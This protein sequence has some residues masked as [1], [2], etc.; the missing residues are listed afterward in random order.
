MRIASF[1]Q[2]VDVSTKQFTYQ[3]VVI[4]DDGHSH[5]ITTTEET[6]QQLVEKLSNGEATPR[7]PAPV[8]GPPPT[9]E[10][11]QTP[12]EE[13]EELASI[14]GGEPD[15]GE[16]APEPVMGVIA[17]NRVADVEEPRGLGS[18]PPAPRAAPPAPRVP[19]V[20]A[21]GF[22]LPIPSRTVPKDEMGYPIVAKNRGAPVLP[23]DTGD[24]G[25]QI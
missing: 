21:D 25:N 2:M 17:E 3:M 20:D 12:M 6:I 10:F 11:V 4:T 15:P 14:F 13:D 9:R 22:A 1:G 5:A 7:Q 18:R 24:D 16:Q 19:R 8:Y 23:E